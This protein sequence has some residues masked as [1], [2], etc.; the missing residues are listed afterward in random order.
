VH[1]IRKVFLS[2]YEQRAY[3]TLKRDYVLRF[4]D[5]EVLVKTMLTEIM[6]LRQLTSGFAYGEEGT[7]STGHSKLDELKS[8]LEEIGNH[9]VI[10]WANFREEILQLF[11]NLKN[12]DA[13]FGETHRRAD[14]IKRFQDGETK[15]LIANPMSGGHGLTFTNCQYAVYYS[16]NYSYEYQK[17]SQ[18]RIHRIGQTKKC[19]YYYLIADG[20]IDEVIYKVL[21]SKHGL[22]QETLNYLRTGKHG[23]K[24]IVV[25]N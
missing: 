21:Q 7:Y 16:L 10:I 19:T 22:S 6:K 23:R 1:V 17:Q 4:G 5:E 20:T 15:Y 3:D 11:D 25:T 18:D 24:R 2:P 13:L 9:Q 14:V 8:L 12:S